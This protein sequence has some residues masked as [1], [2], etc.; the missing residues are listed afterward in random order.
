MFKTSWETIQTVCVG[1]LKS[2]EC[3]TVC[4]GVL[5]SGECLCFAER[6]KGFDTWVCSLISRTIQ[7]ISRL[8]KSYWWW[9][10]WAARGVSEAWPWTLFLHS[11]RHVRM[12]QCRQKTEIMCWSTYL[13]L[14]KGP[15]VHNFVGTLDL[16]E[17][18][19]WWLWPVE[20]LVDS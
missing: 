11:F 19:W 9:Q 20:E 5:K 4:V 13:V 1:V 18:E 12:C 17:H 3:L 6:E 15:F 10:R 7:P 8:C 14:F 16:S 2:G